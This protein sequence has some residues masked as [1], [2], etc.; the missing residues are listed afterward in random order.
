MTSP[1]VRV[2]R[3][4]PRAAG[5]RET[6]FGTLVAACDVEQALVAK[7]QT[8]LPD[9]L[10]EVERW[11]GFDVG[12]LPQPRSWVVSSEVE[13]MPEDQT[14][15]VLVASPGLTDPPRADGRG[16]YVARWRVN[17]AVHLSAA[18]NVYALRNARLYALALRALFAQQQDLDDLVI[19][20]IEW[21]DERY[22]TLPSIDDRTVCTSVV[23]FA[24]EVADVTTRTAGPLAPLLPPTD[25]G[26][27]PPTDSPTWPTAQTAEVAV[28]KEPIDPEGE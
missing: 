20:R 17:V 16:I 11:R 24:V 19:R 2:A 12:T 23:E 15:A 13:R 25:A 27:T 21:V 18:G 26:T 14:P 28:D 3:Y 22:D 1:D 7:A 10:A 4:A 5:T 6:A 9:Y 8:W